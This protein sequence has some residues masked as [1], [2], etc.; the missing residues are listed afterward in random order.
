LVPCV[1]WWGASRYV[2]RV[3]ECTDRR[4]QPACRLLGLSIAA[5]IACGISEAS[6]DPCAQASREQAGAAVAQAEA[7]VAR[8]AKARALWLNAREA[9]DNARRAQA[10]RDYRAACREAT[11]AAEFARLGLEQLEYPLYRH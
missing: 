9:L 2:L 3:Y 5:I 1:D 7:A 11:S 6:S 10:D 8:A 4:L